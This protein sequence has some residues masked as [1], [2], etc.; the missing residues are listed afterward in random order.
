MDERDNRLVRMRE[1]R[2]NEIDAETIQKREQRLAKI[3]SRY[4]KISRPISNINLLKEAFNY[5]PN[6]QYRED[7]RISIGKMDKKCIHYGTMKFEKE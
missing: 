6:I 1:R 7:N 2:E 5:I 4:F 3:R